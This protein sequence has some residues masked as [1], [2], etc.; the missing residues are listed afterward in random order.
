MQTGGTMLNARQREIVKLVKAQGFVMIEVLVNEFN[1]SAQTIRRDIILLDKHKILQRFHGGAGLPHDTVRLGY[2]QKKS[3]SIEGK[4]RIGKAAASLIADGAAVFLDVGTTVETVAQSLAD[5]ADLYIFTNSLVSAIALA[6]SQVRNVIV[7]GGLIHGA[8][9]SLVGDGVTATIQRFKFDVAVIGCSGFDDDGAVMDF[10]IQKVG[11]KKAAMAN[12][13]RIILVADHSK[14]V[15]T[16]FIRISALENFSDL[17]T[18]CEP[19]AAL[20]NAL[21][22]AGVE[23]IVV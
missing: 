8:D 17:V 13:R 15:H 10:D 1:V 21:Q 20:K 23:V 11:V 4:F 16:A 7:T 2:Q 18:D 9:G 14:F 6:G 5:R 3:V 12:A 22:T 19:P